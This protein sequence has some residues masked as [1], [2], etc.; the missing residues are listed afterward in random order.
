MT[1]KQEQQNSARV[2]KLRA[3][4]FMAGYGCEA[5]GASLCIYRTRT[6]GVYGKQYGAILFARPGT[7][8]YGWTGGCGFN[9][10]AAAVKNLFFL[11]APELVKEEEVARMALARKAAGLA[12]SGQ[13][14]LALASFLAATCALDGAFET[15]KLV[16]LAEGY[17]YHAITVVNG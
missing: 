14:R 2:N 9:K 4:E 15:P 17:Y 7:F 5:A 11:A 6:S 12:G 3:A 1:K 10:E 8:S 13:I 16:E